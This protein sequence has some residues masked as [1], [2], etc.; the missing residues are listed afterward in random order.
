MSW[1][2][3]SRSVDIFA[4]ILVS[5][6]LIIG[7]SSFKGNFGTSTL[8]DEDQHVKNAPYLFG[9][10]L[11]SVH[12]EDNIITKNDIF[13]GILSKN[14]LASNAIMVLEHE[15]KNIFNFRNI[16]AGSKYY[17]IRKH[18]C[19]EKPL[20]IVYEPD[21]YK[22]IVCELDKEVKVK[23]VE[24]DLELCEE[25]VEGNI[26]GSLW[27]SLSKN[28]VDAGLIDKMEEALSSQVDFHHTKKDD[29]F[30][31]IYE[32][33][34]V[35]GEY[36]GT[37]RL[38]AAVYINSYGT[39]YSLL[40]K[41]KETEGFFD[42]EGR[43]AKK[44]FL[45]APVKF[46]NISSA[47]NLR[48]FHPIKQQVMAHL[49]TDYAAPYG[50]EIR[51]VA[52]GVVTEAAYTSNNGYYVKVK[53]DNIYQTQY[54]H[55]SRFAKGIKPGTRVQQGET[56]GYVGATGLATGPHVCF[57]FW[58]NGQ[59]VNHLKEKLPSAQPM[60]MKE[61]PAFFEYRDAL[62]S[63]LNNKENENLNIVEVKP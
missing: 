11:D 51:T 1:I 31:L 52:D 6:L 41:T 37:G 61:L 8:K 50:T 15:S 17:V 20:A 63:K 36:V 29:K 58:K 56:I 14:G 34:Y 26:E 25:V 18:E 47:Y 21:K 39:H 12:V 19:D 59:Q 10:N 48:R 53:H 33:K 27:R 44:T 16:K 46:T 22:Y 32:K 55:M 24:K 45:K 23:L 43:P 38:I 40:Y 5:S 4:S 42:F 62:L 28:G 57:R 7:Y 60:N 3:K 9:Y 13:G 2:T 49:G 30:K 35:E 54:L